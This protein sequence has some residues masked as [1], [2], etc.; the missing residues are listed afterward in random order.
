MSFEEI[1]F[2][3]LI[4]AYQGPLSKLEIAILNESTRIEEWFNACWQKTPALLTASV[5]LRYAGFKIAPVDTNIFPAGFNNLN[6]DMPAL[7]AKALKA[8]ILARKPDCSRIL[9]LPE[10]HTRNLFYM[11]S[12]SVLRDCLLQAGFTVHIGSLD[13][14]LLRPVSIA[15]DDAQDIVIEPL[16]RIDNQLY[17]GDFKPCFIF[18]NHDLSSGAPHILKDISQ[19]IYPAFE[20]GWESRLKSNHFLFFKQV[21][22][23]FSELIELD[24]WS[25]N[26]IFRAVDDIDFMEQLG[27]DVLA[28]VV[29]GLLAQGM[30]VFE[31]ASAAVW[32]HGQAAARVGRGLTADDLPEA[33]AQVLGSWKGP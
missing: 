31:A 28:G 4:T 21:A 14:T 33:L 27:L 32:L 5:D 16:K 3:R 25:I 22:N 13:L 15:L 10:S 29:V 8:S 7:C 11:K 30:A 18:L 17:V 26:P 6:S 19:P 12:L 2:P 24:S 9:I 1:L 20:L 23:E